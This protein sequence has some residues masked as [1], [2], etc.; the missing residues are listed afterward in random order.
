MTLTRA[1]L[2]CGVGA[3]VAACA[4]GRLLVAL[5]AVA[6]VLDAVDGRVA[7]RTGT[8]SPFG[9]RFDMEVDAVPDPGAQRLRRPVGRAV[10]AA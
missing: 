3:L 1:S 10:G 4:A 8:V 5:A 9:A 6:L 7:R 2:A